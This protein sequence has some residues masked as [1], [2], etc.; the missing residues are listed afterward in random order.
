MKRALVLIAVLLSVMVCTAQPDQIASGFVFQDVNGNGKRD[1]NEPG[2]SGVAVSNGIEVVVTNKDG[3]YQL[4]ISND[5]IIFVIKPSEYKYPLNGKGLP[6][7]YYIHKPAGS[8]ELKY[9]GVEPTGPLPK[10]V[11]FAL[12]LGNN[13]EKFSIVVFS[14]PQPYSLDEVAYYDKGIVEELVGVEGIEF[15]LTLGDLVGDRPDFFEPLNKATSRITFPFFHVM[16]NHDMNHGV[17]NQYHA[18]E[19][20]ER[21]Y[22]PANYSF[23]QGK[24]HFFVLDNIIYPNTYDDRNY[25]GGFREDQFQ[26]IENSLKHVPTDYLIVI[27]THIPL[28]V[29]Y[30]HGETFLKEHLKRLFQILKD[31]PYTLSM[32]GH[33]HTQ[34]HHYFTKEE[35]WLQEKPHHHYNVATASGDWW[36]GKKDE[37][38]IPD[39]VMRDGS[40][41]GYTFIH[42]DGNSYIYDFKA[43]GHSNKY[44]MRLYAPKLVPYNFRYRG[45]FY[46]NFFQGSENCKVDYKMNDGE[47]KAMNYVVEQDPFIS[48]IR[49]EWDFATSMPEGVRP[50]NPVPCYHLWKVR[51]PGRLPLGTN[52]FY[53]KVTDQLGREYSDQMNFEV[54]EV[55]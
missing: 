24:V 45:D 21:V 55:E 28:F 26:F 30:P 4:P 18:D 11:D 8:P 9:K 13:S 25:V 7:F 14:D 31:R 2:V 32:S 49:Y 19:S 41:K 36:S 33:T 53:V 50:S 29:E 34:R 44:K 46:V 35:G 42:F 1:S 23:N 6:Q 16:G 40:P 37:N 47:W 15:G 52:T 10:S 39:A 54:V 51:V 17:D 38:G 12:L 48:S 27:N 3:K 43:A 5:A 20:F 22:G